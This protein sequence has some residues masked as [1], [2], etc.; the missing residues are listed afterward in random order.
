M[1]FKHE[2]DPSNGSKEHYE[3]LH[4]IHTGGNQTNPD[5][6]EAIKKGFKIS[7][8]DMKLNC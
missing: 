3:E 1:V 4:K 7:D 6:A 8:L 5:L 2:I